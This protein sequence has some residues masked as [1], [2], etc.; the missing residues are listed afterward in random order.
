MVWV[1]VFF[2]KVQTDNLL[3][4]VEWDTVRHWT[5]SFMGVYFSKSTNSLLQW[6]EI[7]FCFGGSH[8]NIPI[9]CTFLVVVFTR[10]KYVCNMAM[11]SQFSVKGNVIEWFKC[12]AVQQLSFEFF[13]PNRTDLGRCTHLYDKHKATMKYKRFRQKTIFLKCKKIDNNKRR[14]KQRRRR[15]LLSICLLAPEED[16]FLLK[17][18]VF[19]CFLVFRRLVS[20]FP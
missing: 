13:V 15:W 3:C 2:Q 17:T 10:A 18:L 12:A 11:F 9:I 16:Q 7:R 6:N 14:R 5:K 20:T 4:T 19:P 8:S 1:C